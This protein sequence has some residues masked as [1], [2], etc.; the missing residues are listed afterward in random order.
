MTE[1]D[2]KVS[3]QS[4]APPAFSHLPGWDESEA[5]PASPLILI[6]RLG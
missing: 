5:C 2:S 6:S 4:H 3:A 1:K